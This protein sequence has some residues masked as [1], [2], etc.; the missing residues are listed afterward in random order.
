MFMKKFLTYFFANRVLL[1][2]LA[3]FCL[4]L[5]PFLK[6]PHSNGDPLSFTMYHN[7]GRY[8]YVQ[9]VHNLLNMWSV[10]DTKWYVSIADVGYSD[11]KYPFTKT[12]NKAFLPTYPILLWLFSL[13]FFFGN[14][15]L[16]GVF[17]SN[18]FLILSILFLKKLIENEPILKNHT[19]FQDTWLYVLLFPTSYFLSAIYPESFFLLLSILVFYFVQRKKLLYACIA[20][21]IASLTKTFGIFLIIPILF[22]I[23]S[24]RKNIPLRNLLGYITTATLLPI[25]YC[26]YMYHISGDP[27][28]YIHIQELFFRHS[29]REPIHVIVDAFYRLNIANIWNGT[30]LLFGLYALI[31]SYKKIPLTYTLYGIFSILFTPLTGVLDGSSR[32]LASLFVLPIALATIIKTQEKKAFLLMSFSLIQGLALIWWL[33]GMGF[34]S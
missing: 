30:F 9:P 6:N 14:I 5:G 22:E 4:Q 23:I 25:V 26:S 33:A 7:E 15:H 28:A 24:N 18:V 17:L 27:F 11:R 32:Y 16:A 2:I 19:S 13:L 20:F 34:T 3:L 10:W 1:V 31:F 8:T 29:W 12:D 21:S